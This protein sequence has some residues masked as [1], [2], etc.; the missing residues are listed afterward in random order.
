MMERYQGESGD[1]A[2]RV[3]D[4]LKRLEGLVPDDAPIVR[5]ARRAVEERNVADLRKADLLIR[6]GWPDLFD[7]PAP[8]Y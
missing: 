5:Q 3:A 1:L 6:Q 8:Q 2:Q 7:H 4:E